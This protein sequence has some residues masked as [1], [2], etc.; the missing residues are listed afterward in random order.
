[1]SPELAATSSEWEVL[2]VKFIGATPSLVS[3]IWPCGYCL[4]LCAVELTHDLIYVCSRPSRLI[5]LQK[6]STQLFYANGPL[7]GI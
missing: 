3:I 1:V 6:D 5:G 4:T 7:L 2:L